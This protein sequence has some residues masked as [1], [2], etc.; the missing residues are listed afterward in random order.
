M[1]SGNANLLIGE[2]QDANREIGVPGIALVFL[3]TEPFQ[4][5]E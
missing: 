1:F 3:D 2:R 5:I 4:R